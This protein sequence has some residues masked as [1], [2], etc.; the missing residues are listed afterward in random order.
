M[1]ASYTRM[2]DEEY[3]KALFQ[4]RGAVVSVMQV[5]S[6][7][8][9]DVHIPGAAGEVEKLAIQLHHRLSGLDVPIGVNFDYGP[10]D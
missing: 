10:D 3:A 4:F 1:A 2:N 9:L 7:Y 8:G 6:L 5:F